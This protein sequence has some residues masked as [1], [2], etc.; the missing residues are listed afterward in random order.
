M[1]RSIWS[2][3]IS[4]GLVNV[5]VK[6]YSAISSKD[7]RFHQLEEGTGA[8]I[9]QKRVSGETG[10][11]VPYERIV[12]A[13]EVSPD[14]YVIITPEDLEGLN[15]K[16]TH[17][18]D[19]EGFVDLAQID[20]V[21]YERAYYLVPDQVGVKAYTLLLRAMAEANKV[22]IAR[23]VLRTKQYLVAI[24]ALGPVLCLETMLFPDEVVP[25]SALDGLPG[26]EVEVTERELAMAKVLID[27]L[28]VDF[29][30]G[31]YHD[32]YRERVLAL[33]EAKAEGLE[34]VTPSSGSA[35][36]AVIDLMAALE[37]SLAAAKQTKT[38]QTGESAKPK[39]STKST[40]AAKTATG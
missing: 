7:V 21:Y 18:V 34:L 31:N 20:P 17:T 27:S 33:I 36:A 1:A 14:R 30:P 11:E 28:S 3:S 12:K 35:P 39:T 26:G 2:G 8:R 22:G 25:V 15:A 24:R 38:A 9:R 5:P 32:E 16:A 4:F 23:M 37:A 19:I 40:K 6:L 10:D 29:E 13:Y